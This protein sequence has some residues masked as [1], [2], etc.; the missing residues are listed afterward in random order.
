FSTRQT[1]GELSLVMRQ[2]AAGDMTGRVRVASRDELGA[3]A[4]ELNGSLERIQSLIQHVRRT[5]GQVHDQSAQVVSISSESSQA[6]DAQRN[7]IE[8]VA[9]AMNEMAATSQEVARSAALAATNAEQVDQETLSGRRMVEAP[10]NCTENLTQENA[11]SVM[12]IMKLA[13][14]KAAQSRL[15]V[16]MEGVTAQTNR[17]TLNASTEVARPCE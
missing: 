11:R 3:L 12:V 9:T 5:S 7:Q 10:A 2:V 16:V 8:Q 4:Q 6:V 15:L 1:I 17:L 13:E 14:E